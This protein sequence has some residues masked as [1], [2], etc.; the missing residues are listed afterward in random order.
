M[1]RLLDNYEK[2]H[3]LTAEELSAVNEG[4][5]EYSRGE[6]VTD[7]ELQ[8]ELDKLLKINMVCKD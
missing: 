1:Y 7:E 5:A 6:Y 4:D 3:Q 2:V 8:I